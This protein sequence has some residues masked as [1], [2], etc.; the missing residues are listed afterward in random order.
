MMNCLPQSHKGHKAVLSEEEGVRSS[1]R[2][3]Q[4]NG[5][6][7]E[8]PAATLAELCAELAY[9]PATIATAIDGIFIP[10]SL[11]NQTNIKHGSSVEIFAPMQGG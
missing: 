7:Y 10:R 1:L 2:E 4:L 9:E 5:V 6:S 3:I 8:T 11:R